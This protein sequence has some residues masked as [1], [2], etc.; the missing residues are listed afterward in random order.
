MKAI[1]GSQS[2]LAR[3]SGAA[4]LADEVLCLLLGSALT[5]GLFIGVAHFEDVKAVAPPPE[6]EDLRTAP[7]VFEPPPPR[8]E[9]RPE[10]AEVVA[11]LTGLE[12]GASDSPV[13]LSVVPP[14]LDKI[15]PPTDIPPRATIQFG[16]LLSDLKPKSGPSGEFQRIY[17]QNEVDQPPAAVIKTIANISRRIREDSSSLRV[18]LVLVVD[19]Q[20]AVTS[21][22][23]L[24]TSGNRAFDSIVL[25]CVRDEWVF[26]PA[27]KKGRKVRCMVQQLVWY[28]WPEGSKFSI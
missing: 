12:I 27:V 13:R 2:I 8:A 22:R 26:S 21:I 3:R 14:D 17:Q 4:N 15:I 10:Q 19:T 16:Q 18:T 7:A 20:G 23:V 9:E 11:P 1:A 24:R 5:L 6:I 28:K 25:E